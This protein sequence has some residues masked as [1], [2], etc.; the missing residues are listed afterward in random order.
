MQIN[1][2]F[3]VTIIMYFLAGLIASCSSILAVHAQSLDTKTSFSTIEI[4]L[5]ETDEIFAIAIHGGAVFGQG[6]YRP[7]VA[8]AKSVITRAHDALVAGARGIDVVEAVII[9][10]ENSGVFNAGKGAIANQAGVVE[11]DALIME[12]RQHKAGAVASVEMVRNPISAARLVMEQSPHVML[13]GPD[14]ES[15]LKDKGAEFVDVPYFLNGGQNYSDVPLPG[16]IVI[17]PPEQHISADKMEFSGGWVGAWPEASQ[18]HVLVVEQISADSA[19]V[20]YA[21]GP[22]PFYPEDKGLYRRFTAKFVDGGLQVIEPSE[23][24]GYIVTYRMGSDGLLKATGTN[25]DKSEVYETTL[26]PIEDPLKNY[27]GGTVGAVVRDRCGDLVAGTSTG[28]FDAKI[29]GRVGDSPIIGAGTYAD[30]A[31]AAISSTGH[32][33]LFMRYVVAHE[34]TSAMKYKGISL[35]AAATHLIENELPGK[36]LRGGIIAV[37]QDGHVTTSYNTVGM[38]RGIA[39]NTLAPSIEVY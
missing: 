19:K 38:V 10:M 39:S 37:D 28:G 5:C 34:I 6:N 17:V 1:K 4:G 2:R 14:A 30:N 20:V 7:E 36:G 11:M 31:T 26:S 8:A 22:T 25:Q 9:D 18:N 32:G 33:E 15:F 12:G 13:V 3:G 23:L 29:P 21:L 16:D 35:Q 27:D 24:G